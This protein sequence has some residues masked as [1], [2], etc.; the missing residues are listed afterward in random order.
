MI[1]TGPNKT[2][3]QPIVL[4]STSPRRHFLLR[5]AG[6][7]HIVVPPRDVAEDFPQQA[8][9]GAVVMD[10]ARRKAISVAHAYPDHFVIGA[11]TVVAIDDRVFGKPKSIAEAEDMLTAI[12]GRTHKVFTGVAVVR[13][14]AGLELAEVEETAVTMKPLT[15]EEI[16]YYVGTG[17]P[18]DKAGAY[19]IQGRGAFLVERV[20]GDYFNVVGLPLCRLGMMLEK[21]GYKI[22]G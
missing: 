9:V 11:D 2:E 15:A 22:L 18:M 3:S 16:R 12:Q 6:I 13:F 4:A 19:A 10:H 21:L 14:N 5:E 8:A 20:V 17:E 7:H 1:Q